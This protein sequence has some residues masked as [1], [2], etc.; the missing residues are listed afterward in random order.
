MEKFV[1]GRVRYFFGEKDLN[2]ASTALHIVSEY[3]DIPVRQQVMD[4]AIGMHGAGG[5]RGQCGIVEGLLMS[6]GIIGKARKVQDEDIVSFC[7]EFAMKFENEFKSLSCAILRPN[8][9]NDND[10][11]HLCE[12]LTGDGVSFG[13]SLIS[14]WLGLA[15][16]LSR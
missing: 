3:F 7:R 14:E 5:Y 9:F 15:P 4:A 10:P 8:G 2:C 16:K 11:P 12:G 6:I 1:K 13:I